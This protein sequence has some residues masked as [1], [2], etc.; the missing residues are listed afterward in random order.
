MNLTRRGDAAE[1]KRGLPGRMF[2]FLLLFGLT[3][4]VMS[5]RAMADGGAT[6]EIYLNGQ[7][8]ND[9]KDGKTKAN[10]VKTF[11]RAKELAAADQT[12]KTIWV[13]GTTGVS[14]E[15]SLSGTKAVLK[16]EQDFKGNLLSVDNKASFKDITIDGNQANANATASLVRVSGQLDIKEGTLIQNNKLTQ[17]GYFQAMGGGIDVES[18]TVNMTGG[19]IRNNSANFGGGVFVNYGSFHFSGGTIEENH[20]VS[21]TEPGEGGFA[22]GGGI[23][24]FDGASLELTDKAVIRNNVS[25]ELGGGISVGTGVA[26]NGS[27]TLNMTGG[28]VLGNSAGSAGGGIYVQAGPVGKQGVATISAGEIKDNK[29]T[30]GGRGNNSFGGAGIYVN[31]YPSIYTGF[32]NGELHLTDALVTEN[33]AK[34]E[35]GG[36][37]GCPSSETHIY[38][39]DGAAFYANS[40]GGG[41]E[42]YILA[43]NDYGVHSGNPRYTIANTMLGAVPYRWQYD[44]G[45]EVPLSKLDGQLDAAKGE[46]LS[47]NTKERGNADTLA[48]ARVRITGNS[49]ATRGGGIG[50]NGT[51]FIGTEEKTSVSAEKK[52]NDHNSASRP[53]QVQLELYRLDSDGK[54]TYIGYQLI[55]ADASGQ[56]KTTFNNLLKL[57]PQGKPY[58]YSVKERNVEGYVSQLS[59]TQES[60]YIITNSST[61]TVLVKKTWVG[62]EGSSVR[63][64]LYA[65]GVEQDSVLLNA[66]NNWRHEFTNLPCYKSDNGSEILYTISEDKVEGYQTAISGDAEKGFEITNTKDT[67][68]TPNEPKTPPEQPKKP[69]PSVKTGD[70]ADFLLFGAMILIAAAGMAGLTYGKKR[71]R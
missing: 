62:P 3:I 26:S 67:P 6:G 12:I 58:R 71:N 41:R 35:G 13:S 23:C 5:T 44:D 15:V 53:H 1:R 25:D 70:Q 61:R 37:A 30:A 52:W 33:T 2:F 17:L 60:G 32:Q 9:A 45:K 68:N 10:A 63:V 8:G 31:G 69:I 49:S 28:S 20:A 54:E 27:D 46:S 36:Y 14:G 34:L 16:R 39:N 19:S 64:R 11:A 4:G 47:L 29:M 51:V 7:S 43:S 65:N 66:A 48:R 24:V 40:A 18:G 50:S 59:G 38:V 21:G 42:I 56:W 55:Q 57:D 22:S